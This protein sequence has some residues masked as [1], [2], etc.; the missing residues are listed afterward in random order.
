MKKTY[1]FLAAVV[2]GILVATASIAGS[3]TPFTGPAGTNPIKFPAAESDLN[4]LINALNAAISNGQI[5]GT[6]VGIFTG[7]GFQIQGL[8]STGSLTLGTTFPNPST[9]GSTTVK[10]FLTFF[11]S[12]GTLSYIPVWQ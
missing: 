2:V 6:Q 12:N 4:N 1:A 7:S 3:V 10:F 11:A 5:A 8:T 9:L